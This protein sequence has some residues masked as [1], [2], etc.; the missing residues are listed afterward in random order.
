MLTISMST[1]ASMAFRAASRAF[2]RVAVLDQLV[3]RRV[4]ADHEALEVPFLAQHL[5]QG[6]HVGTG[7]DAVQAVE[8]G[9]VRGH[10]GLVSHLKRF[11]VDVAE[12][13]LGD[14]GRV[15]VAAGFGGTIAHV[16]LR[17]GGD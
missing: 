13:V 2:G 9:H 11:Q 7:R 4:V 10:A 3:N 12:Q 6:E 14:P 8:R 1:P 16:M 17:A 15:V 5:P